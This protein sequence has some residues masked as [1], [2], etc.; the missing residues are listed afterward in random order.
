MA[1]WIL[2]N[3][4]SA[5][6]FSDW[7]F[8]MDVRMGCPFQNAW[9][10]RIWRAWPKFLAGCPQGCPAENFLLG[11]HFRSWDLKSLMIWAAKHWSMK[12]SSPNVWEF[13]SQK[14]RCKDLPLTIGDWPGQRSKSCWQGASEVIGGQLEVSQTRQSP[15]GLIQII[16]SLGSHDRVAI[17]FFPGAYNV[18]PALVSYSIE[19]PRS[20]EQ[21]KNRQKEGKHEKEWQ[22]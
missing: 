10:S 11:L 8:F 6:S 21:E 5:R 19:N 2:G 4:K 3:E 7:S 15:Y 20:R 9:F 18:A 1:A 13:R 12:G 14:P 16:T 22:N 17:F